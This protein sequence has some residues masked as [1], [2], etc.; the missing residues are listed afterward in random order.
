MAEPEHASKQIDRFLT[1]CDGIFAVAMT[2]LALELVVPSGL[3]KAQ[4]ANAGHHLIHK[5]WAYV[6][7]FFIL[8]SY[9]LGHSIRFAYVKKGDSWFTTFN[10]A[11]L[12]FVALVPP[13]TSLISNYPSERWTVE[14]YLGV[15]LFIGVCD[16]G[17]W[18]YGISRGIMELSSVKDYAE[19][20]R[21]RALLPSI[22]GAAMIVALFSPEW[23]IYSSAIL[24][25]ASR[26]VVRWLPRRRSATDSEAEAAHLGTSGP[27]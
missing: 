10:L 16:L 18:R 11:S 6:L 8:G 5:V 25:L 24:L 13:A 21:I 19:V 22:S 27:G 2:L 3:D 12:M 14:S 26:I 1:L 4:L 7:S 17:A 15:M 9:W 20:T 23:A